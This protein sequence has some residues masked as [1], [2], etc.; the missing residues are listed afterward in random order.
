MTESTSPTLLVTSTVSFSSDNLGS[1]CYLGIYQTYWNNYYIVFVL[2]FIF[3]DVAED[4]RYQDFLS[5]IPLD[6]SN[7]SHSRT[8]ADNH[9]FLR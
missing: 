9:L 1:D 7:K 4:E 8:A 3:I 6:V 5:S 2:L